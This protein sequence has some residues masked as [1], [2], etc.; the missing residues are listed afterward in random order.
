MTNTSNEFPPPPDFDRLPDYTDIPSGTE[1]SEYSIRS[2]AMQSNTEVDNR[3][4]AMEQKLYELSQKFDTIQKSDKPEEQVTTSR[5]DE[6]RI[7]SLERELANE[8]TRIEEL[9]ERLREHEGMF[10][11]VVDFIYT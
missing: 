2:S 6:R 9:E 1:G 10:N 7:R 11:F 3:V 5:D 4:E 8:K